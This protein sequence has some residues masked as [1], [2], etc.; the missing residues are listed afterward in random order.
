MNIGWNMIKFLR[1]GLILFNWLICGALGFLCLAVA[2]LN[3][4]MYELHLFGA[5]AFI[6]G[7]IVH[8]SVNWMHRCLVKK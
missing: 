7:F 8:I 3:F 2:G 4:K 5:G 1:F 6:L